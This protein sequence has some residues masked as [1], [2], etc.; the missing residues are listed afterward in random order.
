MDYKYLNDF[1]NFST[2]YYDN[3]KESD[4]PKKMEFKSPFKM[5][6]DL[7]EL[8]PGA[9]KIFLK[10]DLQKQPELNNPYSGDMPEG[11]S[12]DI[13]ITYKEEGTKI[14]VTI[15]GGNRS[16]WSFT[17]EDG[18]VKDFEKTKFE[19]DKKSYNKLIA[20]LKKYSKK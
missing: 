15:V 12:I 6:Y 7:V 14:Y 4:F 5:K 8:I 1:E 17:F 10:Y 16:W 13:G 9:N 18:K 20:C 3:F 19:L 11:M 2:N